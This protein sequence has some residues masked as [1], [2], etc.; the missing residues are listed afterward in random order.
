[1]PNICSPRLEFKD[2]IEVMTNLTENWKEETTVITLQGS[3]CV[4]AV[5]FHKTENSM[6]NCELHQKVMDTEFIHKAYRVRLH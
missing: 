1:M 3:R 4:G 5:S 2:A 6:K